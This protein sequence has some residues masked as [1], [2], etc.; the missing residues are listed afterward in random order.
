MAEQKSN[1]KKNNKK[2]VVV[3]IFILCRPDITEKNGLFK[4]GKMY[5]RTAE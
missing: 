3:S 1:V 4:G 2:R 5:G